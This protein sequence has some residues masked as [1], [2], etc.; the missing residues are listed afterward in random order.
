METLKSKTLAHHDDKQCETKKP[1]EGDVNKLTLLGA[2]AVLHSRGLLTSIA[3]SEP[4][5]RYL[6]TETVQQRGQLVLQEKP[7]AF[8]VAGA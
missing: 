7:A 2:G 4:R 3:A 8:V 5:G 6:V 1:K